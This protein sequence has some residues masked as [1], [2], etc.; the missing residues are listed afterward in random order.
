MAQ[1]NGQGKDPRFSLHLRV[2]I[3]H[4]NIA[5]FL[6]FV[7]ESFDGRQ[8]LQELADVRCPQ[9][10]EPQHPTHQLVASFSSFTSRSRL[11]LTP[12]YSRCFARLCNQLDVC[13]GCGWLRHA[14]NGNTRIFTDRDS[15]EYEKMAAS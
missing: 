11:N 7:V 3:S 15:P 10:A 4:D 2:T 8:T 5:K 12:T 1:R 6:E 13:D 14:R 9:I